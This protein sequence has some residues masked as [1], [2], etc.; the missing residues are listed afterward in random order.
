[1]LCLIPP[2]DHAQQQLGR[3]P[4]VTVADATYG[5][6]ENCAYLARRWSSSIPIISRQ[7]RNGRRRSNAWRMERMTRRQMSGIV[8]WINSWSLSGRKRNPRIASTW[9]TWANI[10]PRI[11]RCAPY[12]PGVRR[13]RIGPSV[14]TRNS[15]GIN[16]KSEN[17]WRVNP[18]HR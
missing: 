15:C 8:P 11:A 16:N 4:P 13:R 12:A 5:S 3:L 7:P 18:A 9:F 6:E 2:L 10:W 1:M 14:S 17:S